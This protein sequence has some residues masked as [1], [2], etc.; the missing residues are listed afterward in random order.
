MDLL[1]ILRVV[2]I[3]V[4]VTIIAYLVNVYSKQREVATLTLLAFFLAYLAERVYAVLGEP[5]IIVTNWVVEIS[6][7][8]V[9]SATALLIP[10]VMMRLRDFYIFPPLVGIALIAVNAVTSYYRNLIVQLYNIIFYLMGFNIW[11]PALDLINRVYI[12]N[13]YIALFANPVDVLLIPDLSY[14]YLL[15]SGILLALPA[16]ILFA[17]LAWRE[18]SGKALGFFIGLIIIFAGATVSANQGYIPFELIGIC[19][20]AA[21]IF[22][23]IDKYVYRKTETKTI[24]K[25]SAP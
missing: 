20:L 1:I 18:K 12:Q 24:I 17:I 7:G 11:Y 14:T 5:H 13:D 25:K 6:I 19:I 9:L 22:G 21:G 10:I 4:L 2:I 15:I 16:F 3:T 8:M 23:L